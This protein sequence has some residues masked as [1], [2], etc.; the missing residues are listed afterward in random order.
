M[1]WG[2]MLWR[3]ALLILIGCLA[4]LVVRIAA[5]PPPPAAAQAPEEQAEA[6]KGPGVNALAPVGYT[7]GLGYISAG[8]KTSVIGGTT[9]GV[10][11]Y[12]LEK[13][14]GEYE[15][16]DATQEPEGADEKR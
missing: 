7:S 15:V 11:V 8:R 6:P 5:N 13:Y 16:Q 14:R 1:Q 12:E 10:K 2:A 9:E 3:C 4:V